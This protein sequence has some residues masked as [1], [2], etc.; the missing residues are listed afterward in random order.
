MFQFQE[1]KRHGNDKSDK[2]KSN[3]TSFHANN[4]SEFIRVIHH[5]LGKSL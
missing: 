5:D 3:E 1:T 2:R 4:F